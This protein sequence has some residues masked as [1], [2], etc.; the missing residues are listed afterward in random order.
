MTK[1]QMMTLPI[2][3]GNLMMAKADA[4]DALIEND[5]VNE[6]TIINIGYTDWYRKILAKEW[7]IEN[8]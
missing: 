2:K 5:I 1:E 8:D 6:E 3:E 7:G 4:L